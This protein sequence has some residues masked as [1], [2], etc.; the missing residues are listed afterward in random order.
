[1]TRY[2]V[3]D[4]DIEY[5]IHEAID[6]LDKDPKGNDYITESPM[7]VVSHVLR[8]L[9]KSKVAEPEQ[10]ENTKQDAGREIDVSE[11]PFIRLESNELVEM[12]CDAYRNG[13]AD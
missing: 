11:Y 2:L 4:T 13:L 6:S 7:D 9:A 12:I 5:A 8:L 10:T 3:T 1:M